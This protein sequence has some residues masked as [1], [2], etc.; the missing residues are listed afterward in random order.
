MPSQSN[1]LCGPN[2]RGLISAVPPGH[3]IFPQY[4]VDFREQHNGGGR[5]VS[6]LEACILTSRSQ[7]SQ[8]SPRKTGRDGVGGGN[9]RPAPRL[10]RSRLF[11]GLGIDAE[12]GVRERCPP[13]FV[14]AVTRA[15]CSACSTCCIPYG[16]L[17]R[18]PLTKP[19]LC[20]AFKTN[21]VV[22]ERQAN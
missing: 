21:I 1:Q 2:L 17:G 3:S 12:R 20:P 14:R 5:E 13:R 22:C 11:L 7:G 8:R 16:Q 9:A 6:M 18:G 19:K 10:P 15:H 4:T